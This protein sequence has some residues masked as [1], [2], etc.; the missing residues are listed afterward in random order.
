MF[1]LQNNEKGEIKDLLEGFNSMTKELQKN[2]FELAELER[3]NAWKDMA[4]Q[5]AHEIKNPL[6]PM[7]LPFSSLL[8]RIKIKL[9]TLI[10]YLIRFQILS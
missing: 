6:T 7:K 3:E 5:V 2:Q 1:T 8:S 10:L 9:R 4:K